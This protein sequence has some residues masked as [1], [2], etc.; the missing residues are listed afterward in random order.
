MRSSTVTSEENGTDSSI[1]SPPSRKTSRAR[2]PRGSPPDRKNDKQS[3]RVRTIDTVVNNQRFQ[4][5]HRCCIGDSG[6]SADDEDEVLP[7]LVPTTKPRRADGGRQ[8]CRDGRKRGFP[9]AQPNKGAWFLR[10]EGES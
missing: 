5:Y 2:Q 7:S 8:G 9:A 6:S 3:T 10:V 4:S 1:N